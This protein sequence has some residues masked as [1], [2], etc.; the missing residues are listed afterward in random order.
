VGAWVRAGW[1]VAVAY[2]AGFVVLLILL[3]WNPQAPH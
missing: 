3:G 2:V 1:H